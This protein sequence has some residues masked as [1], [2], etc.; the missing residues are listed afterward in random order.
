MEEIVAIMTRTQQ[1]SGFHFLKGLDENGVILAFSSEGRIF[2]LPTY[3]VSSKAFTVSAMVPIWG[4]LHNIKK[5]K[6]DDKMVENI[7][8]NQCEEK[9]KRIIKKDEVV[10][11]KIKKE[12]LGLK[13]LLIV[14]KTGERMLF[15]TLDQVGLEKVEKEFPKCMMEREEGARKNG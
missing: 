11:F 12:F 7:S 3:S 8:I 2:V 9:A 14:L 13:S 6:E 10:E 1:R 4:S 5:L 15:G